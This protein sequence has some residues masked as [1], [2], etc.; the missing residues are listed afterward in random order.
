MDLIYPG[1]GLKIYVPRGLGGK[2]ERVVFEAVHTLPDALIFWHLDDQYIATTQYVH[3][4]QLL[5]EPGKHRLVL[6]DENGEELIRNFEA[7]E[8]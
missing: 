2:K 7:V 6:V 8:P 3:Q 4:V 1:A 5:P